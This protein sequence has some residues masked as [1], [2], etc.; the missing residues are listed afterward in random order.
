MCKNMYLIFF[1]KCLLEA[2]YFMNNFLLFDFG[3]I[4]LSNKTFEYLSL[5]IKTEMM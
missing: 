5:I 3:E 4:L 2:K 1:L